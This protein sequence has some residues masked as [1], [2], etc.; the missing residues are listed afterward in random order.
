M[1]IH[2]PSAL[3]GAGLAV[4]ASLLLAAQAPVIIGAQQGSASV[5][6][7]EIRRPVRLSPQPSDWVHIQE[8]VDYVV[9]Q[10]KILTL[11]DAWRF[12]TELESTDQI[13]GTV[14]SL[15]VI[16]LSAYP[17][18]GYAERGL[19]QG[20]HFYEG[21]VLYFATK[22]GVFDPGASVVAGYLTDAP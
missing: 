6:V 10:G 8:G 16:R 21:D 9:P 22:V 13:V 11:V 1:N 2:V 19:A 4:G 12:G 7:S 3:V 20:L 15:P 18:N 5:S 14:N 17:A